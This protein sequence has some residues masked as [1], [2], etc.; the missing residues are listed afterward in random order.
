MSHYFSDSVSKGR[1][2]ILLLFLTIIFTV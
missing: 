1:L 2:R